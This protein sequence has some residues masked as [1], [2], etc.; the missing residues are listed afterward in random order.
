MRTV[1]LLFEVEGFHHREIGEMLD[2]PEGTSKNLLFR[3]KRELQEILLARRR[4][5]EGG[6]L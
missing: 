4:A 3:A 2:I 5:L 1:F 6:L